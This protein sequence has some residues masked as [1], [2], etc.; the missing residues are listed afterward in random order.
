MVA[1]P[2]A[3]RR[4][5]PGLPGGVRRGLRGDWRAAAAIWAEIGSPYHRVLELVDSGVV[6]ATV[7]AVQILDSLGAS[8]AVQIGRRRLRGLG[9]NQV[10][11]GRKPT[12]RM[13]SAGLTDRQVEILSMLSAGR[14]NAEIAAQLVVSVRTVDHHVSA[15]L[16]KLGLT[17]RRQAARAAADL[18]LDQMHPAGS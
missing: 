6:E 15:V 9:V 5:F 11:R 12:T 4:D 18:G 14:T 2:G 13:N 3:T 10:P 1:S 7:E 16:Q 8:P 17:S